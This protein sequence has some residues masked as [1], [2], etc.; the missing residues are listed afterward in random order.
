VLAVAPGGARNVKQDMAV[1]RWAPDR[2]AAVVGRL[3][4]EHPDLRVAILGAPG[5]RAEADVV[6]TAV[7]AGRVL[8]LTGR[9][10]VAEARAVVAAA[11]PGLV[12]DSGLLHVAATT[13]TPVVAVFGP[14]DPGIL[15]PRR[16]GV[17]AVWSP[18]L[19]RACQDG[20][21]GAVR[22]CVTPCCMERVSVDTVLATVR[23]ALARGSV[24]PS[25]RAGS[26]ASLV[27]P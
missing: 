20:R 9:T 17:T 14:T 2:W 18:A 4:A 19:R 10:T 21:T 13:E 16:P 12:H 27:G 7:P 3:A 1:K 5:D 22:A 25:P 6:R 23:D 8:D 15:C 24:H 11:A 26:A